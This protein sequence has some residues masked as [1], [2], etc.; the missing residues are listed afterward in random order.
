MTLV[1]VLVAIAIMGIAVTSIV[2][3]LASASMASGRHRKLVNADAIVRSDAELLKQQ[4]RSGGYVPQANTT[5]YSLPAPSNGYSIAIT[6]VS[7][8]YSTAPTIFSA[9]TSNTDA[10]Q[11]LTLSAASPDGLDTETLD[12]VL[13][14]P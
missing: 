7:C 6:S 3:G 1:E 14:K 9:C 13:R 12:I 4:V 2:S 8:W 11:K 10:A 5:S